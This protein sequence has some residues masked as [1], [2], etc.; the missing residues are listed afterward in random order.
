MAGKVVGGE[1][2]RQ[3]LEGSVSRI[4]ESYPTSYPSRF[5]KAVWRML[6]K[7]NGP[8]RDKSDKRDKCGFCGRP[9]TDDELSPTQGT[10]FDCYYGPLY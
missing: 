3:T 10:C 2:V 8:S 7:S 6:R 5:E 9:L 1:G 4:G